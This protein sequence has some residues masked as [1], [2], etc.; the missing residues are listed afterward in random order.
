MGAGL[1]IVGPCK[2]RVDLGEL[3]LVA[4][5]HPPSDVPKQVSEP[6]NRA[7]QLRQPGRLEPRRLPGQRPEASHHVADYRNVSHVRRRLNGL[8][9]LREGPVQ[10]R[11]ALDSKSETDEVPHVGQDSAKSVRTYNRF[12]SQTSLLAQNG[13]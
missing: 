6:A 8:F 1:G 5:M 13:A 12:Q 11:G 4:V 3:L 9:P 7:Q 2:Q 10:P